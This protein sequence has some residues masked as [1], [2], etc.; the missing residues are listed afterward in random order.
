M[1]IEFVNALAGKINSELTEMLSESDPDF[2]RAMCKAIFEWKGIHKEIEKKLFRIHGS[3]DL[4]IS[5]PERMD[6][7]LPGGHLLAM[8]HAQECIKA[9]S[10]FL[11]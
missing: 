4:V 10:P 6:L 8:T 9:I 11:F 2:I 3:R 7:I 5:S 1:P